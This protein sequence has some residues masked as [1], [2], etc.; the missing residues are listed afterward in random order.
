MFT[1]GD[2]AEGRA[3]GTC[4]GSAKGATRLR[5]APLAFGSS[6]RFNNHCAAVRVSDAMQYLIRRI[7][8][9]RVG[10]V[11]LPRCLGSQLAQRVTVSQSVYCFK[12][13]FRPH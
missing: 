2:F 9:T 8:N 1:Y 11:E 3:G 12:Y 5:S 13:Q 7:L 6:L 4:R 10:L